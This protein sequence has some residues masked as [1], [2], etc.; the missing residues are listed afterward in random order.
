[1]VRGDDPAGVRGDPARPDRVRGRGRRRDRSP[2]CGPPHLSPALA[3][4]VFVLVLAGF[5]SKAGLVPLH[6]WLPRAHPEAPSHVSALMTA[7]M[8]NLGVYGI[9]AGRVRPAR[10]RAALVVAAGA[11]R[12]AR[13]SAL[14][15]ILQ[16]A[17]ATDLK[18]LLAYSTTENM[19]LVLVGVGAA[20]MFAA[21][22]APALA[23]AR[24]GRG[25]AARGQPRRRSRRCCSARPG[26]CCAPPAP[27][28]WTRSAGCA[29]GCRPPRS[30]FARRGARRRGAAAG[31]R[32]RLAS[33][34]CCSPWC[35]AVPAGG[36]GDRGGDAARGRGGR[37]DRRAGGGDV[38]QG[39]R[40][41]VPR[42]PPQRR[43]GRRPRRVA[44]EHGGRRWGWRRWPASVLALAPDRAGARRLSRAVG[45]TVQVPADR[46]SAG[47]LTLRLAGIASTLSPALIAA[48]LLAAVVGDG[49]RG[50]AGRGRG[51]G[52]GGRS[53]CGT[54]ARGR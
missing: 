28:T 1:M 47:D 37:A 48:A 22:R 10:R 8:V 3:G 49:G 16:A 33:G 45:A 29:R 32:V 34:C 31:Q 6:V 13:V 44:A 21:S 30:L 52:A 36:R 50:A 15:G 26:R 46:S 38:R 4:L 17:V 27:A 5:G 18:R 2:R 20:G 42:P 40:R 9:A 24:A 23:G 54:A 19:G 11:G 35:T 41:R 51:V 7:A 39:V 25:A 12:S 14:Y 53:R 43:R